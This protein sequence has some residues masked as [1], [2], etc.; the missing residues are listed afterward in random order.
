MVGT[1][2]GDAAEARALSAVFRGAAV[3]PSKPPAAVVDGPVLA[4]APELLATLT[5]VGPLLHQ[6]PLPCT[7]CGCVCH[8]ESL[9]DL[10]AAPGCRKSAG[11]LS[12]LVR[13]CATLAPGRKA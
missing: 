11:C 3:D 1:P 13:C 12:R 7:W 5:E 4:H 8:G 2:L 10:P 9:G 6:V